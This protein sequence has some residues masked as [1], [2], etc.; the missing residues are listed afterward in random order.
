MTDDG[1]LRATHLILNFEPISRNFLDVGNSIRAND[2]RLARIDVV[3]PSLS[4]SYDLPPVDHPNPQGIPL[5]AQPLQQVPLGQAI[6]KE[7]AAFSSSLE[8]EIDKFQFE[9]EAI[10]ISEAEEEA[11]EYSCV[12]IPA[13]I[14]TYIGDSSDDE[15]EIV[16]KTGLS[17]RELMKSRNKAP[18]PQHK[19]KSKPLVNPPPSPPQLPIDLGLKPNPNL[20]RKRHIEAPEEGEMALSKGT[21]SPG[22]HRTKGAGGPT[23]LIVEK[24]LVWLKCAVQPVLGRPSWR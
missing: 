6:V 7:G 14:V 13:Q 23:L 21:S 4:A 2:Y 8:E 9:E 18:S 5:A 24:S 17:L 15:E 11:D 16:P 3:E 19:N 22:N 12:Q 20:R 1:Q 10:V